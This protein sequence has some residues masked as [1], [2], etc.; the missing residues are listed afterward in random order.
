MTV[1]A[2]DYRLFDRGEITH[3]V[4]TDALAAYLRQNAA[5]R[6]YRTE[7]E[8]ARHRMVFE[9]D[10]MCRWGRK[11]S[12]RSLVNRWAFRIF[13]HCE[14]YLMARGLVQREGPLWFVDREG[15]G[16]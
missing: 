5:V 8:R 6:D 1:L 7:A 3:F 15:V 2:L 11:S 16:R 12:F 13:R 4:K 9:G 10:G 14:K